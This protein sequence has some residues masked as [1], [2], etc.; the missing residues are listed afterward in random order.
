MSVGT[1]AL[2]DL[3]TSM[4]CPGYLLSSG[5]VFLLTLC[6]L[7]FRLKF[8]S[9]GCRVLSFLSVYTLAQDLAPDKNCCGRLRG[10]L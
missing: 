3:K 6:T 2:R 4:Q 8:C 7:D 1:S 5:W 9:L 10:K